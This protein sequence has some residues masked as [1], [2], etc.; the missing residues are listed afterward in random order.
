MYQWSNWCLNQFQAPLCCFYCRV[1]AAIRLV[2]PSDGRQKI[3]FDSRTNATLYYLSN[4]RHANM[5]LETI[6]IHIYYCLYNIQLISGKSK[7]IF[8]K[9]Y[10][11]LGVC[12]E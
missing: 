12:R 4:I 2:D 11:E 6:L 3:M 1:L 8:V 7:V 9:I 5:Y 10:F